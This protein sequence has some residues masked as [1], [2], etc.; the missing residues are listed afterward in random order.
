MISTVKKSKHLSRYSKFIQ[1]SYF[2][3]YTYKRNID[4]NMEI[5]MNVR[6]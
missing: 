4:L 3:E 1:A 6:R 2:T 5:K